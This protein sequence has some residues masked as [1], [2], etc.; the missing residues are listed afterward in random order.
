M[1]N[2]LR[3][4]VMFF[5]LFSALLTHPVTVQAQTREAYVVRSADE[6]TLTFYYDSFRATR[7]GTVWGV[8][9]IKENRD[10]EQYPAWNRSSK[11]NDSTLQKVVFDETFR[12]FRPTTTAKWFLD[13]HGLKEVKGLAYLNTSEVTDMS[14]MFSSCWQLPS[15]DVSHFNT[16]KVSDMNS[17][18]EDC[19]LL[20]SLDLSHFDTQNVTNMGQMF[21]GCLNL[22]ALDLSHF[23]TSL[24]SDLSEMF[25][26]CKNMKRLDVS[27]FNTEN[28]SD[29]SSMFSGCQNLD[30]LDLKSFNTQSVTDM[31]SMFLGCAVLKRLDVSHFNTENVTDMSSMFSGCRELSL[32][33]VSSFSTENTDNI[34]NMFLGCDELTSIYC[35]AAWNCPESEGMFDGCTK[36]KGAI[37]YDSSQ[38]DVAMANPDTGYF[39]KNNPTTLKRVHFGAEGAQQIYTL[40]G[41]RVRG[42]WKYGS[43]D[44]WSDAAIVQRI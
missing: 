13:S 39:T 19:R 22:S 26:A 21:A 37:S 29:M 20:S 23:N 44:I 10:N 16:G 7:T 28:V 15:L 4:F 24:V 3:C 41:Q 34:Q 31:S 33:D 32:L 42:G 25:S 6:S 27:H 8:A 5:A 12:D 35:K 40:Q 30:S 18:F 36:L 9:D 38:T 43:S 17:M 11:R 2:S 14:E 1:I